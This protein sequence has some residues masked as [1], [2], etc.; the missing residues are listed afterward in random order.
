MSK[1]R[2][3]LFSTAMVRAILDERKTQTRR[4]VKVKGCKPFIPPSNWDEEDVQQWTN[5][6]YPY[7][8]PGDILWVRETWNHIPLV[9]M[10]LSEDGYFAY[11][12]DSQ[13]WKQFEGWTWKPS[14]HMPFAAARIFLRVKSVRV[15]RLQ[16]ISEEDAVAEGA[17]PAKIEVAAALFQ[18]TSARRCY[19]DGFKSLWQS[20]NGPES[21][22]ANPWVWVVEFERITREEALK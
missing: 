2:P 12:T 20:I 8:K 21:W 17:T 13:E 5:G 10:N 11:K 16:D 7:G 14:I 18:T 9:Y 1:L 15:E 3:I 6:Y 4:V 19:R 22:D